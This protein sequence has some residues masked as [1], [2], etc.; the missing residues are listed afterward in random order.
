[1]RSQQAHL[2]RISNNRSA[3]KDKLEQDNRMLAPFTPKINK[4]NRNKDK[5]N[6]H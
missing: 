4:A 1:V 6:V 2:K 5:E 3:L